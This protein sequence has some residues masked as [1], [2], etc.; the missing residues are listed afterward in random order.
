[1]NESISKGADDRRLFENDRRVTFKREKSCAV[2]KSKPIALW[3]PISGAEWE[4][5]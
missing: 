4:E 1:M 3:D 2:G 5:I